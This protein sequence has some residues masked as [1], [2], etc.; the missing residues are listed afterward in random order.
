[1]LCASWILQD[2]MAPRLSIQD[3][4]MLIIL[5]AEREGEIHFSFSFS[6]CNERWKKQ[7]PIK[8]N[9]KQASLAPLCKVFSKD[10]DKTK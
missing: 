7:Q 8:A 3:S 2:S 9:G 10:C 4:N 6:A 5:K 1:M